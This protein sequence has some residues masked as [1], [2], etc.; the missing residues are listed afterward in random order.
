MDLR[1]RE[2]ADEELELLP[3]EEGEELDSEPDWLVSLAILDSFDVDK[4]LAWVVISL[5]AILLGHK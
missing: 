3:V 1:L 2:L 5:L 4:L